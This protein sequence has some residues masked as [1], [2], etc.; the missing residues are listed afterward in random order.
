MSEELVTARIDANRMTTRDT[1]V[2]STPV[3]YATIAATIA[4]MLAGCA[5]PP[6]PSTTSTDTL[7][8]A[9]DQ[10]IAVQVDGTGPA[11]VQLLTGSTYLASA[12]VATLP[13]RHTE[14][15][16]GPTMVTLSVIVSTGRVTCRLTHDGSTRD[17]VG[18][19]A[20]GT[21]VCTLTVWL[22]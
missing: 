2:M 18:T 12:P 10:T 14:Q 4:A 19:D 8:Q 11:D 6:A 21:D 1:R 7:V 20:S 5:S 15:V 13:D 9:A 3:K 17:V 22:P 16:S